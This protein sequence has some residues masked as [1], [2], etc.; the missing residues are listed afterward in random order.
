MQSGRS[1]RLSYNQEPVPSS[2]VGSLL[3]AY[4]NG[5]N[6][7]ITYLTGTHSST[8]Y[9]DVTIPLLYDLVEMCLSFLVVVSFPVKSGIPSPNRI[10]IL[11]NDIS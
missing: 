6:R 10:G 11:D 1:E 3:E 2:K 7:K 9:L 4:Q 8:V 5:G